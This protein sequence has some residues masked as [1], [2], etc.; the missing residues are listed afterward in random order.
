MFSFIK[1][2][3]NWLSELKKNK[4]LWFTTLTVLSIL[5]ISL[6]MY[7]L[8]SMT[9]SVAKEVYVNMSSVYKTTLEHKLEEKQKEYR[10]LVLGL[11]LNETFRNNLNNK[12]IVDNIINNYNR[13][14]VEAG[15]DTMSIV[16]YST[17][18]QTTQYRNSVNFA[19]NR[20]INSFGLEILSTGPGMVYLE[21]IM[22]GENLLGVVEVRED[23]LSLKK[24]IEKNKQG[25][26]LF[27]IQEKMMAN[28]SIDAKNGKYRAVVDD[29]K[30]EEQK[31][32]GAFF[33]DLITGGSDGF[34]E[35]KHVGYT[36]NE[37]FFRTY[38]EISDI[39]GVIVGYIVLGEKV[40]GSGAFVNIVDN[41]TK[42]VTT[43]ALGLVV[44]ILLFM[45]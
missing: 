7:I 11:K 27:L 26:F 24:D 20:K 5:G 41:M 8:T 35:F 29:L 36:V 4:G 30:V 38:K 12:P 22:D 40:Q 3:Q 44:S 15:F 21:P 32:D 6:S 43:V 14:L 31:Y 13:S 28:L 45:F 33:A 42:T 34:K 2:I 18:N 9:Q 19:I 23:L 25:I 16:F 39:N 37:E 10:K 1:A 17:I